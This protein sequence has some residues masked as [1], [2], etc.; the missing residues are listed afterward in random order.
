MREALAGIPVLVT[1]GTGFLG[2]HLV[3]R[4]VV[5]GAEVHL[6]V[7]PTSSLARL[8]GV[9]EAVTCHPGDLQDFEGLLS[10]AAA[11]RPVK[12]FHLAA[13]TDVVRTFDNAEQVLAVN[14]RGTIN[15]LRAVA[16]TG[17]DCFVATGTCEEYGDNPVPFR[18]DQI[19]NP[20]SPYSASKVAA[21]MFCQM[22]HRT[23]GCPVVILRP[24]LTYGPYQAE[25]RFIAQ[26]I[27]AALRGEAF[28]MTGGAQGRELNY[29]DD[30][31][32]GFVRAATT[33]AALGQLINL[34]NGV[35]HRMREVAE[36]IF[37]L[38]GSRARPLVGALPYRPV[39]SWDFYCDSS[40]ARRLLGWESK[41]GVEEGLRRTIE[42]YRVRAGR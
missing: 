24:F 15:L 2:S 11:V 20:V 36:L 9:V 40:K 18:E 1:G 37:R 30:I 21:T 8:E 34:G 33:P 6:L 17:H 38:A 22:Y 7:R 14:L 27:G 26:A 4:L 19:P 32:E 41:V 39:E 28:P 5:E 23:L 16:G 12:V 31:V 42:W 25:N 10:V 29:V 13:Y 3:R 35:Q